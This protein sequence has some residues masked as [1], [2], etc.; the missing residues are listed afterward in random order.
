MK[1]IAPPFVFEHCLNVEFLIM[2]LPL[3]EPPLFTPVYSIS[4]VPYPFVDECF[5]FLNYDED[6]SRF[7][8]SLK[9]RAEP[10][11]FEIIGYFP[12][13]KLES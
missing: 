5:K 10:L 13:S 9:E 6:I 12:I 11:F 2:D 8:K 1:D 7:C 3:S 4:T